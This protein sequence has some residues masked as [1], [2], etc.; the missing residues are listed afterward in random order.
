MNL[1]SADVPKSGCFVFGAGD[2]AVATGME[3]G[4]VDICF[5]TPKDLLTFVS[6]QIPQTKRNI[7]HINM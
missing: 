2:E 3:T 4:G 5:V 7:E 6:S 1:I